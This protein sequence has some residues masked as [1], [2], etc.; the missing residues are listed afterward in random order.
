MVSGQEFHRGTFRIGIE[1]GLNV[2]GD[3]FTRTLSD[4]DFH[5]SGGI[6]GEYMITDDIGVD[7]TFR[8]AEFSKDLTQLNIDL[9]TVIIDQFKYNSQYIA[10]LAG[11]YYPIGSFGAFTPIIGG[12]AGLM[13]SKAS[14]SSILG[15]K[16]GT[17]ETSF[18][19]GLIA[20]IDYMVSKS[21]S[22]RLDYCPL[23]TTSDNLDGLIQGDKKDGLSIFSVGVY[24]NIFERA[25]DPEW[26]ELAEIPRPDGAARGSSQPE[27][28]LRPQDSPVSASRQPDNAKTEPEPPAERGGNPPPTGEPVRSVTATPNRDSGAEI[29]AGSGITPGS[30]VSTPV[31][32]NP[33]T[34]EVI[35]RAAAPS[36]DCIVTMLR[37]SDFA[38]L[39][40]LRVNPRNLSL[41]VE[42]S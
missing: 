16:T 28:A 13:W 39:G 24:W 12:R 10:G 33:A 6:A 30:T 31:A 36:T 3:E 2:V 34:A 29:P 35:P 8:A 19:Y 7:L 9:N 32:D 37:V 17:W 20:S 22:M 11:I 18:A 38:S 1:A 4:Y 23:L 27:P 25:R 42:Q 14:S 41:L 26:Q 15:K 40:E 21:L 5:P